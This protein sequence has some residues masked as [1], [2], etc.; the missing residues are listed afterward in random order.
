MPNKHPRMRL[1]REE[2]AFLRHWMYDET[3]FRDG[4]GPAK[5][6]QLQHRAI[7]ADLATLI[8]AA[9]PEPAEQEAAGRGPPPVA[10]PAWPWSPEGLRRRVAEAR[11]FLAEPN[12]RPGEEAGQPSDVTDDLDARQLGAGSRTDT[13]V[14]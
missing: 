13:E 3:H 6:L 1:S 2:E 8:A 7:P 14:S 5:R 9:I 12:N 10:A 4:T 11:A